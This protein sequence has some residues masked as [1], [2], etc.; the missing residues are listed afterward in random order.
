MTK[1]AFYKTTITPT[2]DIMNKVPVQVDVSWLACKNECIPEKVSF[3]LD[4][5]IT[6]HDLRPSMRWIKA[7]KWPKTVLRLSLRTEKSTSGW[8]C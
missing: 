7:D 8:L 4:I 6:G 1:R 2:P 3:Y 5:P